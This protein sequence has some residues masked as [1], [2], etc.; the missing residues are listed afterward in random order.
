MTGRI[1]RL[2]SFASAFAVLQ[3]STTS[4]FVTP[5]QKHKDDWMQL[6]FKNSYLDILE[7]YKPR[8]RPTSFRTVP[9]PYYQASSGTSS[10]EYN[11]QYQQSNVYCQPS[12]SSARSSS[13]SEYGQQNVYWND[14]NGFPPVQDLPKQQQQQQEQQAYPPMR[15]ANPEDHRVTSSRSY[16]RS[17]FDDIPFKSN[18]MYARQLDREERQRRQSN[19]RRPF[20]P[21]GTM[22]SDPGPRFDQPYRSSN[23]MMMDGP[24]RYNDFPSMMDNISPPRPSHMPE[25]AGPDMNNGMMMMDPRGDEWGPSGYPNMAHGPPPRPFYECA[26]FFSGHMPPP[27]PQHHQ[28]YQFHHPMDHGMMMEMPPPPPFGGEPYWGP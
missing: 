11:D 8:Q 15:S 20:G 16:G 27:P 13:S 18:D 26:E 2:T 1:T 5:Q 28:F 21:E 17:S 7:S 4:A 25:W 12:S 9:R 19:D 6:K 23:K 22:S 24:Q 10:G 14:V 3:I